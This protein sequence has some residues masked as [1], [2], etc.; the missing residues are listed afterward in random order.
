MS[1]IEIVILHCFQRIKGE[2]TIYA[3]L[4]LLN[5]K[6][7]SQTIQDI[8]LFQLTALFQSFPE[9]T[10]CNFEKIV[11]QLA[12]NGWL[13]QINDQHYAVNK[14]KKYQVEK[15]LQMEPIPK[16]LKGWSYHQVTTVFWERLSLFVQ[17]ASHLAVN[18]GRYLP[19]QRD[20]NVQNWLKETLYLL[21]IPRNEL[22]ENLYSE[23]VDCLDEHDIQ[24]EYLIIRLTGVDYIG[25]TSHQAAELLKVDHDYFLVYFLS[26]L[27]F[28][29]GR[30][31]ERE[32]KFP[33]LKRMIQTSNQFLGLTR[34][35]AKTYEYLQLGYSIEEIIAARQLKRSTIE[36]HIVEIILNIP[37]ASI[38]HFVEEKKAKQIEAC[39]KR[40]SSKSLKQLKEKLSNI[41]YFEIRIVLAKLG[42]KS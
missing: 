15:L 7:S 20:R 29:I 12:D 39:I 14:D 4:H 42:D 21:K 2:R 18:K 41:S 11:V 19:V 1:F 30:V 25:L 16:Y 13:D 31:L 27:H 23:I 36:D 8:H 17:V 40:T 6:K 37:T 26:I 10:R 32:K 38:H 9:L 28:M 5:G 34:S 22:S 33:I 3:I 24:P 35:T